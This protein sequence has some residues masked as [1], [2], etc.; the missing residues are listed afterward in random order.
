MGKIM[1]ICKCITDLLCCT[2]ETNTAFQVN[3]ISIEKKKKKGRTRRVEW[4]HFFRVIRM[5]LPET[6]RLRLMLPH[7]DWFCQSLPVDFIFSEFP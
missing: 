7:M 5:K 3:Y 2:P 6:F 1:G 4:I